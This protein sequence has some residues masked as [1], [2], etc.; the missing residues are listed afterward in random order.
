MEQAPE[1]DPVLDEVVLERQGLE[2]DREDLVERNDVAVLEEDSGDGSSGVVPGVADGCRLGHLLGRAEE[3]GSEDCEQ[4][5]DVVEAELG[6]HVLDEN[7]GGKG[8]VRSDLG[9]RVG[10]TLVDELKEGL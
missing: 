4:A 2:E 9:L 7:T 8:G 3:D 1:D 10:E 5:H 6:V